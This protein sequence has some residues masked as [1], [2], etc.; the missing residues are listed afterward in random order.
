MQFSAVKEGLCNFWARRISANLGDEA[1]VPNGEAIVFIPVSAEHGY[2]VPQEST[3][4]PGGIYTVVGSTAGF[5][6]DDYES[7]GVY[8]KEG[9]F[10][11]YFDERDIEADAQRLVEIYRSEG[12]ELDIR[13]QAVEIQSALDVIGSYAGHVF[14]NYGEGQKQIIPFRNLG[15]TFTNIKDYAEELGDISA[16]ALQFAEFAGINI[17]DADVIFQKVRP[18]RNAFDVSI[19]VAVNR[20]SLEKELVI[21]VRERNH[22]IT[23]ETRGVLDK[24]QLEL[25]YTLSGND[26]HVS[27]VTV[28]PAID[29][30]KAIN[31]NLGALGV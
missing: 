26:S 1:Q 17:V 2:V 21:N 27:G 25:D 22:P 10:G 30:V 13:W 28:T 19:S 7:V 8:A 11:I 20:K 14:I 23:E 31:S 9:T 29:H 3:R 12:T 24:L 5:F 6:S 18:I 15:G 16:E 4:V